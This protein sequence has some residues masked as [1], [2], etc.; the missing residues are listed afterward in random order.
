MHVER[1][2]GEHDFVLGGLDADG[3]DE[4]AHFRLLMR[5]DMFAPG[6]DLGSGGV[7]APNK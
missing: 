3:A 6:A 7:S 5:D 2:I 1:Q 4:Q